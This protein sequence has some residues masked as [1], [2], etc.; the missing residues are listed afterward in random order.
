CSVT[1]AVAALGSKL[2]DYQVHFSADH[3]L[4]LCDYV[5]NT[6][7]RH[8]RLY[9]YVLGRD[10]DVQLTVARLEV[11]A[12]PRPLP[13]AQGVDR[14]SWRHEQR[15]AELR[16]AEAQ[17]RTCT[18][19]LKEALPLEREHRL[20]RAFLEAPPPGQA[21]S[22][23]ELEN[24]IREAIRIQ[25]ECLQELLQYEIQSTFDILDLKLQK[26][27]LDLSAPV[28]FPLCIAGQPG[29]D[30]SLKLHKASRARKGRAKK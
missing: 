22:R 28:P 30:E 19:L 4:A 25:M 24:L 29:Q 5:H 16:L 7:I 27:V 3:L 8:H 18:L 6:L 12:P 10:Q 17:G 21:L 20:Q 23:E 15:V 26:K 11:C 14:A 13:L 1:A 9:Q 2:G